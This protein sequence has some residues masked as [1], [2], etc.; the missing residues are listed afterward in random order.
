MILKASIQAILLRHRFLVEK[1]EQIKKASII[2]AEG[3]TEAADLMS[4]AFIKAGEG[5]DSKKGPFEK[6]LG[7]GLFLCTPYNTVRPGVWNFFY[8]SLGKIWTKF[9]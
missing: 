6:A 1:A 5:K 7:Q 3:D 8:Q 9:W 4:K 2:S